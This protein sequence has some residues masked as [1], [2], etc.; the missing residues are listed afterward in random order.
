MAANIVRNREP[1][2]EHSQT[3]PRHPLIRL[4]WSAPRPPPRPPAPAA[5]SA[6]DNTGRG[7]RPRGFA[8]GCRLRGTVQ[9]RN[10][11]LSATGVRVP[12]RPGNGDAP[13]CRILLPSADTRNVRRPN[14]T[15]GIYYTRDA[16]RLPEDRPCREAIGRYLSGRRQALRARHAKRKVRYSRRWTSVSPE[17]AP[18]ESGG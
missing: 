7:S 15:E 18:G 12:A 2:D 13:P 6:A 16:A 3:T 10:A 4:G 14:H 11:G 17:I 9:P 5:D 1:T 8:A